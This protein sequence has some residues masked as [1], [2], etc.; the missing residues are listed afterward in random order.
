MVSIK[1][2]MCRTSGEE[3]GEN[4]GGEE[5]GGDSTHGDGTKG[6]GNQTTRKELAINTAHPCAIFS[7]LKIVPT[8]ASF[9]AVAFQDL[10]RPRPHHHLP[11]HPMSP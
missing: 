8:H 1:M 6:E 4:S 11:P 9:S 3:G 5:K 7:I 10:S 2:L